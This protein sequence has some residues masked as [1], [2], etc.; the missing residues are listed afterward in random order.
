[1]REFQDWKP[2]GWDK[3]GAKSNDVSNKEYINSQSRL[4]NVTSKLKGTSANQN[5][6]SILTNARKIENEEDTFKL[7][8]V[9][10]E[11]GK[12]ISQARCDKK[13]SQKDMANALSLPLQTIQS[14]ENGKALYNAMVLNKIEKY[15]GKRV[16]V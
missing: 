14:F 2:T 1:M 15:L 5:K 4:G 13:I 16:R 10:M 7:A 6:I 8:T 11:I 9:G 3:R 12:K